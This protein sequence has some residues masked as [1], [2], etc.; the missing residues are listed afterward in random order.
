MT[1]H[2]DFDRGDL[3]VFKQRVQ[4][5]AQF[6]RGSVMYGFHALGG[7]HGERRDG[8]DAVTVVR[9]EGFQVR[10]DSRA[11]GRIE[12]RD[13]QNDRWG[14]IHMIGQFFESLCA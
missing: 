7:L 5:R 1:Q 4:L 10:G 14:D 11:G 12:S 9:G 6:R 3:N 8:G 13:R 2:S